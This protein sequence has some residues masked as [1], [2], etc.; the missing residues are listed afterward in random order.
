[1]MAISMVLFWALLIL[2]AVAL[3][4]YITR[5]GPAVGQPADIPCRR[6]GHR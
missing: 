4:R 3:L 6:T 5:D 2:I 1:M